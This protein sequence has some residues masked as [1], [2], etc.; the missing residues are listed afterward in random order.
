MPQED[1][2]CSA[3]ASKSG[4]RV[5]GKDSLHGK[6]VE[7]HMENSSP[8]VTPFNPFMMQKIEPPADDSFR[9]AVGRATWSLLHMIAAKYPDHPSERK[10]KSTKDWFYLLPDVYPCVECAE[11][12]RS[13]LKDHPPRTESRDALEDWVCKFHDVVNSQLGKQTSSNCTAWKLY[14][15]NMTQCDQQCSLHEEI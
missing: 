4:Q 8:A 7:H 13:N 2:V 15:R 9:I 11:H 6:K 14:W 12:M 3:D 1:G 5:N 10:Q